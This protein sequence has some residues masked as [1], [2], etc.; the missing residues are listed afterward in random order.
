MEVVRDMREKE[1]RDEM[2][3]LPDEQIEFISEIFENPGDIE[4]EIHD[5][6]AELNKTVGNNSNEYCSGDYNLSRIFL[7]SFYHMNAVQDI[8]KEELRNREEHRIEMMRE[9]PEYSEAISFLNHISSEQFIDYE[10]A[11]EK[12][13]IQSGSEIAEIAIRDF[14]EDQ[15]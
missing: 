5:I 3:Q 10:W 6:T 8:A 1:I 7:N 11:Q 12:I 2:A 15:E 9:S 14:K 4:M 13:E